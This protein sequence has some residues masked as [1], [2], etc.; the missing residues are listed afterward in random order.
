MLTNI[1][2]AMTTSLVKLLACFIIKPFIIPLNALNEIKVTNT[3]LFC[4]V[5]VVAK[6]PS[7]F[8]DQGCQITCTIMSA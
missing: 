2:A 3:L 4:E 6:E 8:N 1:A 7:S 5:F